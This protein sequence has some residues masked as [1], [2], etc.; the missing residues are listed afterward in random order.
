MPLLYALAKAESMLRAET[1][2]ANR[3]IGCMLVGSVLSI[4]RR[5]F[6]RRDFS[7]S[8]R[9]KARICD[10]EGTWPVRSSQNM[11]SG[12]ISVP[13]VPLGR[14]FRHSSIVLPWNRMP[15]FA[16]RTDPSHI[17]ALSPLSGFLD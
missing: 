6:G 15:S 2:Q 12:S 5:N 16:S 14:T 11:A 9:E 10:V 1:M 8:S 17:I 7:A 4:G 3:V 13:E